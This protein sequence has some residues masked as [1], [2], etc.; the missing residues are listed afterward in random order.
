MAEEIKKNTIK[1]KLTVGLGCKY[2]SEVKGSTYIVC[3]A[4]TFC[5]TSTVSYNTGNLIQS[6]HLEGKTSFKASWIKPR[7]KPVKFGPYTNLSW[8]A[9][10]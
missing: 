4:V 2:K 3:S 7:P 9:K 1:V 5:I 6:H 10:P 8:I